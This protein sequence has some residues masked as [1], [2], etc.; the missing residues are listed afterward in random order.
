[1]FRKPIVC[2]VT[3]RRRL[4]PGCDDAR[5]RRCLVQQ[6][7]AAIDSG[8]DLL[9]VRERDLEAAAL[10]AIVEEIVILA[11]SSSTRVVVNDR[12]DVAL[13]AG[14]AGVHLRG[15]SMPPRAARRLAPAGFLIG[16]SVH[17]VEEAAAA[18]DADYLL[19]GTVFPTPS[20]PDAALI[21][22]SGLAAIA[23]SVRCPVLAIGGVTLDLASRV[24]AAGAS[25]VAAI[26]LFIDGGAGSA[27]QGGGRACR[28]A[29][30]RQTVESL[31]ARFDSAGAAP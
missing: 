12:L 22:E 23:R 25:G 2:V 8:V 19:A 26:G 10:T 9:Q 29:S 31:R 6:A 13:A 7:Q 28:A 3:A 16:R 5:A 1:M 21:G 18:A 4:C 15:D 27:D 14:A 30:L 17:G 11:R 24:A 20:K